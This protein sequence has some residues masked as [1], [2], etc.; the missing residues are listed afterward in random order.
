MMIYT[1]ATL[2]KNIYAVLD[3]VLE[4]GIPVEIERNGKRLKIV[5]EEPVGR[6]ERLEPHCIITGDSGDL[7][8]VGW[9]DSWGGERFPE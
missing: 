3:S 2:R 8:E 1:A 4:S 9:D 7:P 5:P 6:L